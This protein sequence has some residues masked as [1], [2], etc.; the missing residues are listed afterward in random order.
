MLTQAQFDSVYDAMFD[1][2]EGASLDDVASLFTFLLADTLCQI[3]DDVPDE[4]IF[5]YACSELASAYHFCC[6]QDEVPAIL[7]H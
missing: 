4:A 5:L 6:E 1:R 2:L 7:T 3:T